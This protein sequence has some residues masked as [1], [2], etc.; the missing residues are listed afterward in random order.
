MKEKKQPTGVHP[1]QDL[2]RPR[3]KPQL[4]ENRGPAGR[5]ASS[6]HAGPLGL[7]K[8]PRPQPTAVPTDLRESP[9]SWL[10]LGRGPRMLTGPQQGFRAAPSL[11]PPSW[12][13]LWACLRRHFLSRA[14]RLIPTPPSLQ[15]AGTQNLLSALGHGSEPGQGPACTWVACPPAPTLAWGHSGDHSRFPGPVW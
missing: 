14:W 15:M 1:G 2:P 13:P 9:A 12:I 11:G 6:R 7:T 8:H 5:T 4:T 10:L 3:P